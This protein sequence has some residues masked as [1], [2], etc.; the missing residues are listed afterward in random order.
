MK[1]MTKG[2]LLVIL[3]IGVISANDE[4]ETTDDYVSMSDNDDDSIIPFTHLC[5][6]DQAMLKHSTADDEDFC[7]CDVVT[8]SSSLGGRPGVKIDC[9]HS[10]HVTN[11]TNKIF[12]AQKLPVNTLSLILSYQHF[13]EVPE[14]I[15]DQLELLDMSN[16]FITVIKGSNFIRVTSLKHLDLSYNAI[17]EIQPQAFEQLQFLTHLDLTSNQIVTLPA[18]VFKPLVALETLKLSNNEGFGGNL[19]Q[20]FHTSLHWH[21]SELPKLKTIAVDRCNLTSINLGEGK[22][23]TTINLAFNNISDFSQIYLPSYVESLDLSGNPVWEF[24]AKSLPHLPNLREL[25]LKVS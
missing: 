1:S 11:L 3:I 21:L 20:S 24:S 13:R 8:A 12:Q 9:E 23:L 14:F 25:F 2:V 7:D 18:S 5:K 16:N 15:G 4:A 17:D 6:F 10:D 22:S 19:K